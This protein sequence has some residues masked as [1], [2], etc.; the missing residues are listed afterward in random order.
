[1][2]LSFRF[3]RVRFLHPANYYKPLQKLGLLLARDLD[4]ITD[5]LAG[6]PAWLL[7]RTFLNYRQFN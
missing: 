4:N 5:S 6:Y 2:V 7:M 3:V 1:M